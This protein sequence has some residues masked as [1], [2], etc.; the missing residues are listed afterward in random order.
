MTLVKFYLT[1]TY[2]FIYILIRVFLALKQLNSCLSAFAR[3]MWLFWCWGNPVFVAGV[4]QIFFKGY[5]C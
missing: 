1:K 3:S 2:L 4:G 5:P